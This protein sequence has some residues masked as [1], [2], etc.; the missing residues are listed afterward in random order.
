MLAGNPIAITLNEM[1]GRSHLALV[2]GPARSPGQ[3]GLR[4][5]RQDLQ[6]GRI[7]EG[8]DPVFQGPTGRMSYESRAALA[9]ATQRG[10][11]GQIGLLVESAYFSRIVRADCNPSCHH[12]DC[13]PQP[14][15]SID[16]LDSMGVTRKVDPTHLR[17]SSSRSAT[18]SSSNW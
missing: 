5:I 17:M 1:K 8:Q 15:P 18:A 4:R 12:A 2:P 7:A 3:P 13:A 14:P 16:D 6:R 10:A 11:V 9:G